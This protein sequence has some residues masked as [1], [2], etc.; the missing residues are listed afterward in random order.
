M[1]WNLAEPK[2]KYIY[3]SGGE[4]K[5]SLALKSNQKLTEKK[6]WERENGDFLCLSNWMRY[7]ITNRGV[8][9]EWW[10][11]RQDGPVPT[12]SS[13]VLRKLV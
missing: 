5:S 4:R 2:K 13:Q 7:L 6:L 1:D 8:V 11:L 12:P 3:I 10:L 9:V